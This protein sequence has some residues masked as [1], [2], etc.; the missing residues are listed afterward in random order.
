MIN[1]KEEFLKHM[2]EVR[3]LI[4][5]YEI[6]IDKII[7]I[8]NRIANYTEW[9]VSLVSKLERKVKSYEKDDV[10]KFLDKVYMRTVYYDNTLNKIPLEIEGYIWY[11][12]DGWSERVIEEGI[13]NG[14][15]KKNHYM[16]KY[17]LS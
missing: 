16:K 10:Y 3:V 17:L 4:G 14:N 13:E 7:I 1:A 15:I 5:K 6:C 2:D 8:D 12:N 9:G 11:T